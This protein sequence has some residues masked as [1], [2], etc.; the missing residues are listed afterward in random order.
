MLEEVRR[1]DVSLQQMARENG[2][3]RT[4]I[5]DQAAELALNRL[6]IPTLRNGWSAAEWDLENL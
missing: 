6:E 4:N 1:G 3:L 5:S 2:L